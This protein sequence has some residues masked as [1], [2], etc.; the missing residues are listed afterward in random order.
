MT[1]KEVTNIMYSTLK[2]AGFVE[3]KI[4]NDIEFLIFKSESSEEYM[5]C[6]LDEDNSEISELYHTINECYNWINQQIL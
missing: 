1:Q 6:K 3:D 2:N 4:H 5:V